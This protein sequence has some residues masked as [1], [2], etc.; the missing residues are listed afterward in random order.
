MLS[1]RLEW[2]KT[3]KE[4][5]DGVTYS[6]AEVGRQAG[7]KSGAAVSNWRH[8]V[9]GIDAAFA[10]PLAAWLGVDA[11]WLETGVGSPDGNTTSTGPIDDDLERIS[12]IVRWFNDSLPAGRNLIFQAAATAIEEH[13]RRSGNI[14][15][16]R[17]N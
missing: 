2:A 7:R 10:R 3:R 5:R 14:T 16:V 11:L 13:P 12:K 4:K 17:K 8:D 15:G 9:N 6:W 1:A